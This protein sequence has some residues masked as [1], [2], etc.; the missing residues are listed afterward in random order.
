MA[1]KDFDKLKSLLLESKDWPKQYMFKFIVPNQD[2]KVE[3]VKEM[4]PKDGKVTYR[5]TKNLKHVS[6]TCVVK[7]KSADDVIYITKQISSVPGVMSL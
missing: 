3:K 1:V 5:H 2:G 6:V 7:M 4:L